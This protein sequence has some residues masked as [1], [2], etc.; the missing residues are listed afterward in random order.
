MLLTLIDLIR[1]QQELDKAEVNEALAIIGT[2]KDRREDKE[3]YDILDTREKVAIGRI[4]KQK[5]SKCK[6]EPHNKEGML[7]GIL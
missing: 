3:Q 5:I 6:M 4:V 2:M 7:C 1:I